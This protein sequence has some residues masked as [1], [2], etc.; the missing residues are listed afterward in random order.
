[1]FSSLNLQMPW[2]IANAKG[3]K[4]LGQDPTLDAA[5]GAP[6]RALATV[7]LDVSEAQ[8]RQHLGLEDS[9]LS[10]L[11]PLI[12]MDRK[13]LGLVDFLI[14]NLALLIQMNRK[15]HLV[16]PQVNYQAMVLEA[17]RHQ[18]Q[19]SQAGIMVRVITQLIP[20]QA[21]CL[22]NLKDLVSLA[23]ILSLSS[24]VLR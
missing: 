11:T 15:Y 10:A 22:D 5:S 2:I 23:L 3:R 18:A 14:I 21:M 12:Q 24:L 16:T 19:S 17:A 13:L 6:Q 1:M 20:R 8:A 7:A 9:L 4:H